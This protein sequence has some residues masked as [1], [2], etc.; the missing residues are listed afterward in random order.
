MNNKYPAGR[1][2]PSVRI[3]TKTRYNSGL[4]IYDIDHMPT[5]PGSWPAF[6]AYGD[7]WPDN[8]EI[9]ILEGIDGRN[10]NAMTLHTSQGCS[11]SPDDSTFFSGHWADGSNGQ[12]ATNC[13][14]NAPSESKQKTDKKIF[15][16]NLIHKL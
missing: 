14:G 8:G 3:E 13:W 2:R 10:F 11:M 4:F 7:N 5:G 9:D 1:G 15:F 6:W 12:P 16:A